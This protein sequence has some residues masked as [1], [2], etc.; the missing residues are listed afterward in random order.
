M[1]RKTVRIASVLCAAMLV[2][3]V[4][5][6]LLSLAL[7]YV[8][9]APLTLP[10]ELV[11]CLSLILPVTVLLIGSI[12]RIKKGGGVLQ[13]ILWAISLLLGLAWAIEALVS[14]V[15]NQLWI[16]AING[17]DAV[18]N[19]PLGRFSELI[20]VLN[21]AGMLFVSVIAVVLLVIF[22]ISLI[23]SKQKMLQLK[24][25][26]CHVAASIMI[27]VPTLLSVAQI[28]LNRVFIS[29]G[30]DAFSTFVTVYAIASAAINLL[31]AL[32]LAALVLIL[33]LVF[34]KQEAP[35]D[36]EAAPVQEQGTLPI[37]LPAGVSAADLDR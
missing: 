29:L 35:A 13:P 3:Y 20:N 7:Q 8:T 19:M 21:I 28:L 25:G 12:A 17:G 5:A 22:V 4:L 33:G 34:K 14:Y 26:L 10:T 37:D 27:L 24:A 23:T 1:T 11:L 32:L 6:S 30:T 31:L 36:A 15:I 18:L 2:L 16:R 9:D